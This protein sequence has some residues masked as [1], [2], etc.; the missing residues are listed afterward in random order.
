MA[1]NKIELLD[2]LIINNNL[3]LDEKELPQLIGGRAVVAQDIKHRLLD[4]GL[5]YRLIGERNRNVIKQITNRIEL[6][7]EDDLRVRAG[8]VKAVYSREGKSAQ[9]SITCKSDVGDVVIALPVIP[10]ELQGQDGAG[11]IPEPKVLF[12]LPRVL[13]VGESSEIEVVS[14]G[15]ADLLVDRVVKLGDADLVV[16]DQDIKILEGS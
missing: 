9:L 15:S 3:V 7:V 6:V 8:T 2:L 13:G 14:L 4:S 5:V 10:E 1:T 16:N 11:E 12:Y